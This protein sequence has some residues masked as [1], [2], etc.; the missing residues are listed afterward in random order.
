MNDRQA[1]G[2]LGLGG[3]LTVLF[4]GLKLADVIDWSWWWVLSPIWISVGLALL[5][6]A[7]TLGFLAWIET[8]EREARRRQGG[9]ARHEHGPA[10][11]W[12]G[13]G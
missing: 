12:G 3:A 4:V 10:H 2:G 1:A 8:R 13:R 11:R 5:V 9:P 7:V 6:I